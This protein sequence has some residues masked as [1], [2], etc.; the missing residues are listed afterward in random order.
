M[1]KWPNQEPDVSKAPAKD[2]N[3][4]ATV[5]VDAWIKAMILTIPDRELRKELRDT[6]QEA[7]AILAGERDLIE[8]IKNHALWNYARTIEAMEEMGE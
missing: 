3:P 7:A 5:Y 2:P 4:L 6:A 1:S 8:E